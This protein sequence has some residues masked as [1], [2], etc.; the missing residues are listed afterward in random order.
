MRGRGRAV[1]VEEVLEV[2]GTRLSRTCTS[3][4]CVDVAATRQ[5]S[6]ML[7]TALGHSRSNKNVHTLDLVLESVEKQEEKEKK[8]RG[9]EERV[10]SSTGPAPSACSP[11][12]H[13]ARPGLGRALPGVV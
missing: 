2:S 8:E 7:S 4:S 9:V 13:E 12:L 10:V 5:T 1:G 3:G 6:R 11:G